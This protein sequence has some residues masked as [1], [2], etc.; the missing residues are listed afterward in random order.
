MHFAD[1]DL[2][3]EEED[4]VIQASTNKSVTHLYT[5]EALF[6]RE[7]KP[8]LNTQLRIKKTQNIDLVV[9][10]VIYH[11]QCYIVFIS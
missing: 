8:F 10:F 11:C 7:L 2:M 4:I 5:L 6:F 1:C 3:M 9:Q